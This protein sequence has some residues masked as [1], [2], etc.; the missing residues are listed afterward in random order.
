MKG[1]SED[2]HALIRCFVSR[3]S[4]AIK[5]NDDVGNYFWTK[6]GLRQGDPLSP[7]YLI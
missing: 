4:V 6:K 7:M 1:F 2:W 5:I 3:G